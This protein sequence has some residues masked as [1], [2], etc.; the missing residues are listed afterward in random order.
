MAASRPVEWRHFDVILLKSTAA[1]LAA[2]MFVGDRTTVS[3]PLAGAVAVATTMDYVCTG[4][5]VDS[6]SRSSSR[7]RT[8][9]HTHTHTV[10]DSA[11]HPT[12]GSA[13][14]VSPTST[15][16]LRK[17]TVIRRSPTYVLTSGRATAQLLLLTTTTTT[18][19]AF[20]SI[21]WVPYCMRGPAAL[22]W[23]TR[24]LYCLSLALHELSFVLLLWASLIL[25]QTFIYRL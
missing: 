5:G 9:K 11:D 12:H 15:H 8:D 24:T 14:T 25:Q 22:C 4:F 18:T 2:L 7:S 3:T 23:F 17:V 10:T 13:T 21:T 6:W 1:V 20:R 19:T 16:K